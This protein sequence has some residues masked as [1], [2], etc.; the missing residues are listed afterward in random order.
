[1]NYPAHRLRRRTGAW[2]GIIALAMNI[3]LALGQAVPA[4]TVDTGDRVSASPAYLMTCA[5]FGPGNDLPGDGDPR[6]KC[7]LCLTHNL[8]S[9]IAQPSSV[10]LSLPAPAPSLRYNVADL[11]LSD[12]FQHTRPY[13]RGPPFAA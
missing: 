7:P 13:T 9:T 11:F 10:A 8:C 4:G 12:A 2:L 5:A 3:V 6:S 1:M